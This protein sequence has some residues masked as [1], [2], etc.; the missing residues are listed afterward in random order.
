MQGLSGV[1]LM[2]ILGAA[3]SRHGLPA[4]QVFAENE[5]D[6]PVAAYKYPARYPTP[7][8]YFKSIF[9]SVGLRPCLVRPP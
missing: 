9:T 4:T 7:H 1:I 5:A 8:E 3:G 6:G 2:A